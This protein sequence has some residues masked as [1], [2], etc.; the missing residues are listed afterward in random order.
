VDYRKAIFIFLSNTG[1]KEI[2][3]KVHDVWLSGKE[4]R[5]QLTIGHFERLVELGAF[6]E[7]GC[8]FTFVSLKSKQ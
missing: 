5:E 1:G 4:K 8:Y 3:K 6:N 2:T 7:E